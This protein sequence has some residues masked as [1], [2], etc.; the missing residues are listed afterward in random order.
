MSK[1]LGE[2][3]EITGAVILVAG[4]GSSANS[5]PFSLKDVS[6]VTVACQLGAAF[7]SVL[8]TAVAPATVSVVC[9]T[10]REASAM[11][12]L[13]GAT[14]VMGQATISE[15]TKW[16]TVVISAH[17]TVATAVITIDGSTFH[18]QT[19]ATLSDRQL[20]SSA[21]SVFTAKLVSAIATYCTHLETFGRVTAGN[22]TATSYVY[23][24]RKDGSTGRAIDVSISNANAASSD[25]VFIQGIK[26]TGI[27]EFVPNDV[28]ATNS[29]YTHFGVRFN[30]AVTSQQFSAVVIKETLS[31]PTTDI[32]RVEI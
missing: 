13:T 4:G 20:N 1:F 29:S 17:G 23:V 11:S 9:G 10:S 30:S 7:S 27:I 6:R 16:D 21:C 18:I 25:C 5:Q 15:L 24:R 2:S 8:A 19:N 31:Q 26:Q 32:N 14:L 28:L 22:A 12:V 3:K